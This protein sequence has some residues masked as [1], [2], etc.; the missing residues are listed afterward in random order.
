MFAAW[1]SSDAEASCASRQLPKLQRNRAVLLKTSKP[2]LWSTSAENCSQSKS[3]RR[4]AKEISR[5]G[6]G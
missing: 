5:V 2:P 3:W 6:S 1:S 4:G